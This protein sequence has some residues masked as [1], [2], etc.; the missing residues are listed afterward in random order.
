MINFY[1]ILCFLQNVPEP[2]RPYF[3]SLRARKELYSKSRD[4]SDDSEESDEEEDVVN[5]EDLTSMLQYMYEHY[6]YCMY[7]G[8]AGVDE[9]DLKSFCPGM[10]R[11]DHD[12]LI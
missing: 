1:C 2:R 5:E 9:E 7:C 6:Y 10:F 3:W 12:D 11:A 8:S 4:D